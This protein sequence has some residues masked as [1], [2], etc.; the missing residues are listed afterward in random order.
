MGLFDMFGGAIT[1][2]WSSAAHDE[3]QELMN[4]RNI[5]F[6]RETNKMN[7]QL[8]REK[9]DY[10]KWQ[11]LNTLAY[12]S[13]EAREAFEREAKWNSPLN[14]VAELR[15]AGINPFSVFGQNGSVSA[16]HSS[17]ASGVNSS[18]SA[19]PQMIAPQMQ[20][21]FQNSGL[22][23]SLQMVGAVAD[24]I[25][26]ISS[27]KLKG[28]QK[29]Q[30]DSL[31]DDTVKKLRA[32]TKNQEAL[33]NINKLESSF[34]ETFG[35]LEAD[36]RYQKLVA[37][38]SDLWQSI[39]LK[40]SQGELI[41]EQKLTEQSKRMLN[42]IERQ[43]KGEQKRLFKLQADN[44]LIVQAQNIKESNSRITSNYASAEQ[45]QA[46][47]EELNA[48]RNRIEKLLPNEITL[49][50]LEK[51]VREGDPRSLLKRFIGKVKGNYKDFEHDYWHMVYL[52]NSSGN[53][54]VR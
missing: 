15:K 17:P 14:Q 27:A 20:Y 30:I 9:F 45:S 12:N 48:V 29:M 31:I 16:A 44:Y 43:L 25:D 2:A 7:E 41:D 54:G 21:S 28:S 42:D 10:D 32:E 35:M 38:A 39:A 5:D 34:K 36:A 24:V 40:I 6:Q 47:A 46:N 37:E 1:S 50:E 22:A 4:S 52:L 18:S 51:E 19:P 53:G 8:W 3:S 49:Q 33:A 13:K 23:A 11:Y 26:K